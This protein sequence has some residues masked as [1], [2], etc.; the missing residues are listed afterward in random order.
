MASAGSGGFLILALG[1]FLLS[2][3]V[4]V[5]QF[6]RNGGRVWRWGFPAQ[7]VLSFLLGIGIGALFQYLGWGGADPLHPFLYFLKTLGDLFLRL[8]KMIVVPLIITSVI[9]GVASLDPSALGR[10]GGKTVLFYL[11]TTL[12]SVVVG[13]ILVNLIQPGVGASSLVAAADIATPEVFRGGLSDTLRNLLLSMAQNPFSAMANMDVLPLIV[14]SLL[15]GLA[16]SLNR[17]K[18]AGLRKLFDE[19]FSVIMRVTDW[20]IRL[21]PIGILGFLAWMVATSEAEQFSRV[22]WYVVTVLL[23]LLIHAVVV[24]P[25]LFWMFTRRSPFAWFR[26][27][28]PALMT[29]FSTASSSGTLPLTMEMVERRGGVSER[30]TSFVLPL[31]AT[32]NMDGTALYEAVAVIFICQ[33]YGFE[34]TFVQQLTIVLVATLA[35]IGAAGIPSAGL[36]MIFVVLQAVGFPPERMEAGVAIILA[37]DRALDM[38]RTTVNVWGDTIGAAIVASSEGEME[39]GPDIQL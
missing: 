20:V 1:T 14:F 24:L 32:V 33:A 10:L 39:P 36:V 37:V 18:T 7:I 15:F 23:G 22:G 16:L 2:A 31:G 8:L 9:A 19:L 21:A 25:L 38:C 12:A 5:L 13:M 29:A 26:A 27:V 30:V 34:L 6:R 11:V 4:A 28:S 35:A 17:E 3:L